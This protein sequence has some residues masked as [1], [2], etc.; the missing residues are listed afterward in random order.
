V[1]R[2]GSPAPQLWGVA[3]LAP[4]GARAVAFSERERERE[5]EERERVNVGEGWRGTGG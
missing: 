3:A 2:R 4:G 5:R 1:A